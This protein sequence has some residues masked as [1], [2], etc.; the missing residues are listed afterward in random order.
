[1][2]SQKGRQSTNNTNFR[3]PWGAALEASGITIET[4][5][6]PLPILRAG[7]IVV[8]HLERVESSP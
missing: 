1:V 3:S 5:G 7:R 2:G 8:F 4:V 6:L